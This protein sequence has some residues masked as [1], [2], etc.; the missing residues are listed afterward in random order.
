MSSIIH[1]KCGIPSSFRLKWPQKA[2]APSS[3]LIFKLA[4]DTWTFVVALSRVN[5]QFARN[6]TTVSVTHWGF[7]SQFGQEKTPAPR[8]HHLFAPSSEWPDLHY[9]YWLWACSPVA[10]LL[11][12]LT[13]SINNIISACFGNNGSPNNS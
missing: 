4:K 13:I 9:S 6:T 12:L 11:Q 3:E 8:H 10:L 2:M 1:R 7:L 5:R